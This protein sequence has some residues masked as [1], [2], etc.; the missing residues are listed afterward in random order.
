[1]VLTKITVT[2][3]QTNTQYWLYSCHPIHTEVWGLA[4]I[5]S[6]VV[7]NSVKSPY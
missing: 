2:F 5:H 7:V 3:P 4:Y 6:Y 1:M